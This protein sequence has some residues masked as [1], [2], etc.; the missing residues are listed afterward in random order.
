MTAPDTTSPT[1]SVGPGA[2]TR[3]DGLSAGAAGRSRSPRPRRPRLERRDGY[4]LWEGGPVPPGSAGITFGRLVILRPRAR[5]R[6]RLLRHE[7]VHVEQ[8]ARHGVAGFL[9]RYLVSYLRL[10]LRGFPHRAA[11]RR[12]PLEIEAY[13]R[14]RR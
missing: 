14:E 10:R 11:Y 6:E 12:I 13:W 4:L 9:G 2:V 8:Y 5:H 3:S 1:T 7:L